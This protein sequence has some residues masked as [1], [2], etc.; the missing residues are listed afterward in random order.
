MAVITIVIIWVGIFISQGLD[1]SRVPAIGSNFTSVLGVV[2][3]NFAMITSIPSWVNEKK[4]SVSI[5]KSFAV[6]MP[7]VRFAA[8]SN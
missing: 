8:R 6:S 4:E 2:V 5:E 3:F 7:I 1:A